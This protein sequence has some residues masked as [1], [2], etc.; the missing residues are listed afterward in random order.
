MAGPLGPAYVELQVTTNYSF[1]R[2]ASHVEELLVAARALGL[3][4]LT[5]AGMPRDPVEAARW[6]RVSAE[7]G[8]KQ[9][10]YDLA[11]LVLKGEAAPELTLFDG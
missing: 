6:F 7:S 8:D 11:H 10:R 4:H 1:L 9:S 5:G 3:M 2:G